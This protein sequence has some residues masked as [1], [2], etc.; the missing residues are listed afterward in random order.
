MGPSSRKNE[1]WQLKKCSPPFSLSFLL[2]RLFA[3]PPRY[4][5]QP[6]QSA[7][8]EGIWSHK[9][10]ISWDNRSEGLQKIAGEKFLEE[11]KE[12]TYLFCD[13]NG[14]CS[15]NIHASQP[16][17]SEW[18]HVT[19]S[20]QWNMKRNNMVVPVWE[21]KSECSFSEIALFPHDTYLRGYFL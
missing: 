9:D 17:T 19:N 6:G 1:R 15:V 12:N 3:N 4:L 8:R 11:T 16:H 2:F 14:Q 20:H 7:W 18:C 10:M 5:L 13:I 21:R